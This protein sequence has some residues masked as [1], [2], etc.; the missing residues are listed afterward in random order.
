MLKTCHRLI[1]RGRRWWG[2]YGCWEG[3]ERGGGSLVLGVGG[4]P[5]AR[6]REL[7]ASVQGQEQVGTSWASGHPRSPLSPKR[8]LQGSLWGGSE[9]GLDLPAGGACPACIR[10]APSPRCSSRAPCRT[11]AMQVHGGACPG[12]SGL[13]RLLRSSA[14][15]W[16]TGSGARPGQGSPLSLSSPP[17]PRLGPHSHHRPVSPPATRVMARESSFNKR[18]KTCEMLP[19]IFTKIFLIKGSD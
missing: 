3:G 13:P 5:G 2:C 17:P 9:E 4:H 7:H 14:E 1:L 18:E 15:T 16:V 10:T 11:P 8:Q 12:Y 19:S 6:W